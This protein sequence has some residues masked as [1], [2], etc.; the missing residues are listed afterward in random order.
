[1]RGFGRPDGTHTCAA[2]ADRLVA[3]GR[4]CVGDAS[5]EAEGGPLALVL[6]LERFVEAV[7]RPPV[8]LREILLEELLRF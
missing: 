2:A 7:E 3:E 5:Y 6:S 1:M 4:E 8:C